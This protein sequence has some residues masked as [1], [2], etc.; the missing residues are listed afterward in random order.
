MFASQFRDRRLDLLGV[1]IIGVATGLGGGLLRDIFLVVPLVAL[2][3]NWYL[4]VAVLS[5]L[6]GMLL[7]RLFERLDT[8][9]TILD[10]LTIGLFGAI[11]TTKALSLG[12]PVIPSI[13]VGV[14]SAVGGSVV[15][16]VLLAMP[17]ALMHVGSLY[18]VAAG[19]GSVVLV[20]FW[21]G[22]MDITVAAV[23]CVLVTTV[24]RL[25]AVRYGWSLPEQRAIRSMPRISRAALRPRWPRLRRTA[26]PGQR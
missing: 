25:L 24:V 26:K 15:R 3:T 8:V 19:A 18:A 1:A 16:D 23:I 17:I 22:G 12:L 4:S 2:H 21:A 10:A 7:V 6:F 13:F 14:V 20:T 11:G 5:A 9:I